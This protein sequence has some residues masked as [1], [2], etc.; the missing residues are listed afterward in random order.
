MP[1]TGTML[2]CG[3]MV[4]VV[5][6]A[7][8]ALLQ[9]FVAPMCGAVHI[10]LSACKARTAGMGEVAPAVLVALDVWRNGLCT[11]P[12][13]GWLCVLQL[14]VRNPVAAYACVTGW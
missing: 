14:V 13:S 3:R 7:L 10:H 2:G 12:F 11:L 1:V 9:M 5:Q 6:L 8:K 4:N